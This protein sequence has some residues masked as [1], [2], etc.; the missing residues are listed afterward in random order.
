M[1]LVD[2]LGSPPQGMLIKETLSEHP[3]CVVEGGESVVEYPIMTV[4]TC[5]CLL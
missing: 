5:R 2:A 1:G 3:K 4:R